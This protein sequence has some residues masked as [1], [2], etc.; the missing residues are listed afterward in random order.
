MGNFLF[1][2]RRQQTAA[3]ISTLF[4]CLLPCAAGCTGSRWAKADPLYAAKYPRHSD[5]LRQMAKQ[6]IDARHI[7]ERLGFSVGASAGDGVAGDLNAFAY[8]PSWA[9][10]YIGMTAVADP[11]KGG[12]AGGRIGGRLQTPSRVAPFIGAGALVAYR[13]ISDEDDPDDID[14]DMDGLIDEYGEINRTQDEVLGA[15]YPEVGIH[16]WLTHQWRL[17]TSVSYWISSFDHEDN[18]IFFRVELARL[19]EQRF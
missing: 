6:A 15:V 14:N 2:T 18:S 19:L 10:G 3:A 13:E 16:F 1:Y 5:D 7:H 12:L 8:G 17:T 4:I 11:D 9:E